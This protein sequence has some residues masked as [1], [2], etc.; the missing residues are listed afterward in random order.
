M[1]FIPK[2]SQE[3]IAVYE[4]YLLN[5]YV[6]KIDGGVSDYVEVI[7]REKMD[8]P[9]VMENVGKGGFQR[10]ARYKNQFYKA[11]ESLQEDYV[12]VQKTCKYSGCG[13]H[14][15]CIYYLA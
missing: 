2:K 7:P 14:T 5:G 9:V 15:A 10:I 3:E 11:I 13:Q 12:V 4:N 1:S 6:L 8:A